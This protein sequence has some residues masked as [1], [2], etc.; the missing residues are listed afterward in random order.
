MSKFI[1]NDERDGSCYLEF[2]I[3]RSDNPLKDGKV[4]CDNIGHWSDNSLYMDRD[5]FNEFYELYGDVFD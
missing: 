2:Q 5:D 3:C 1:Y 4:R